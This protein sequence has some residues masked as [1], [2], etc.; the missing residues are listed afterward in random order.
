MKIKDVFASNFIVWAEGKDI[1]SIIFVDANNLDMNHL[2]I[3]EINKENYMIETQWGGKIDEFLKAIQTDAM[4]RI[5]RGIVSIEFKDGSCNV[6]FFGVS[7]EYADQS[8]ID[9]DSFTIEIDSSI[10]KPIISKKDIEHLK[11]IET[12]IGWFWFSTAFGKTKIEFYPN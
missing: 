1:R 4:D 3:A 10:E 5:L 12:E 9:V 11:A 2:D 6:L 7:E 8:K